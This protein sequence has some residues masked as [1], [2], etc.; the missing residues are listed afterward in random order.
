MLHTVS[1]TCVF[2]WNAFSVC[3]FILF[4][5]GE[6][7]EAASVARQ[8][9]LKS[10]C[11]ACW[12]LCVNMFIIYL[13]TFISWKL[14]ISGALT[15]YYLTGFGTLLLNVV[16]QRRL[17]CLTIRP[18]TIVESAELVFPAGLLFYC[19]FWVVPCS[20]L[21]HTLGHLTSC[22]CY[23]IDFH[24]LKRLLSAL[25]S[26]LSLHWLLAPRTGCPQRLR[27]PPARTSCLLIAATSSNSLMQQPNQGHWSV[28]G[29]DRLRFT[30]KEAEGWAGEGW[31]CRLGF[32][33]GSDVCR[34]SRVESNLSSVVLET[35]QHALIRDSTSVGLKRPQRSWCKWKSLMDV[36]WLR[37]SLK[38]FQAEAKVILHIKTPAKL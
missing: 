7:R 10:L 30:R 29:I 24:S 5:W 35:H 22:V 2:K 27:L 12:C 14:L 19:L 23:N 18:V 38:V 34:W 32:G 3:C 36:R 31:G 15:F 16:R 9:T 1:N 8:Q 37:D 26:L 21:C 4:Q 13:S 20:R 6:M 33:G 25:T 17:K 28:S 11:G